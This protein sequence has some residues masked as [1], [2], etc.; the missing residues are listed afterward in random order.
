MSE[1]LDAYTYSL[2]RVLLWEV[3][4]ICSLC[5]ADEKSLMAVAGSDFSHNKT[6]IIITEPVSEY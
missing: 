2:G 3:K 4:M 1:L 6:N 5:S